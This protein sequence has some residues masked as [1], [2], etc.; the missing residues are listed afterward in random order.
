MTLNDALE[1]INDNMYSLVPETLAINNVY[2]LS[3]LGNVNENGYE[4]GYLYI[5]KGSG[6]KVH[7]H[8][9]DI[10]EYALIEGMLYVSGVSVTSN[11]C[12]IN[13][14]H[15][16][17]VCEVDSLIRYTKVRKDV[18]NITFENARKMCDHL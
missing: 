11:I 7:T 5:P 15:N 1:L 9:N 2:K 8:I 16:I 4:Y 3:V 18:M 14:S 12:L 6:I 13:D 17:D 10:E